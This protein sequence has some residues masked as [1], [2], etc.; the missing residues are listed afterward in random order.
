[1]AAGVLHDVSLGY[2]LLWNARR[3]PD[4]VWLNLMPH[5]GRLVNTSH[6][7]ASLSTQWSEQHTRLTLSTRSAALLAD[8]LDITPPALAQIEVTDSLL[9]DP[10]IAQRVWR[11]RQRGL[12]LVWHGEPGARPQT[13][14]AHSFTQTLLSLSADDVL[15]HLRQ[16]RAQSRVDTPTA[17]QPSHFAADTVLDGVANAG[18]LD[19]FLK[20]PGVSGLMDWPSED[21]LFACR[22]TRAQPRRQALQDVIGLIQTD[23]AMEDVA[24]ALSQEP[25]LVYRFLRYANSAGLGLNREITALRHGLMVLGL[26]R[27]KTWLQEQLPLAAKDINLQPVATLMVMRA[28]FMTELLDAG[29]TS[30]LQQELEL[31]GLLS[32]MDLLTGEPL[33]QALHPIL[34]PERVRAALLGHSGPY[35]PY[36]D[37]ANALATGQPLATREASLRHGF[38]EGNVNLALLRTLRAQH[39]GPVRPAACVRPPGPARQSHP[40][41]HSSLH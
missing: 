37:I 3:Q 24:L 41:A 15:Q 6:L 33:Q 39:V 31:C 19:Y 10:A 34:L 4:Q 9:S 30:A 18:L 7:L 16:Q 5:N 1:M 36:L 12:S 25:L 27:L 11:A 17:D 38:E 22:Q 21:V 26:G 28:R 29:A 20:Q 32:Q 14:H 2:Q 35:W 23:A 13:S 40:R 8:L